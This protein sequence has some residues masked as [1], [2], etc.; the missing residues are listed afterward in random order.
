VE[1]QEDLK[2]PISITQGE[3]HDAAENLE[4]ETESDD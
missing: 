3:S 4:K 2:N 1:H